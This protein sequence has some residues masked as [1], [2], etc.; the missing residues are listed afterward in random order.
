MCTEVAAAIQAGVPVGGVCLS[1]IVNNPGWD[2]DRHCYN[3]PWDY[4]NAKGDRE[5]Y[6]PLA[7]ELQFQ[8]QQIEAL[9]KLNR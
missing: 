1:P 4:C 7:D 8:R 6:H 5:I 2:D 3:D 9:L